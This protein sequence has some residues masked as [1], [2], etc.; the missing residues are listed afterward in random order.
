MLADIGLS[1]LDQLFEV[2]PEALRLAG[3]LDL[4]PG[5]SEPDV[6]AEMERLAAATAPAPTWSAL[7]GPG[8]TTTRC[9]P[10]PSA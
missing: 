10:R 6:L 8:P 1:S 4:P 3:G 7:P 9:R 2:V 5:L